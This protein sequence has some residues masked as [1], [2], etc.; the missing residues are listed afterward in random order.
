MENKKVSV[1]IPVYN[2]EATIV[3]AMKSVIEQKYHDWEM[4]LIDDGSTDSSA[5]AIKDYLKSLLPDSERKIFYY[6]QKNAG[7]SKARNFGIGKA[8]GRFIAFLDSDDEWTSD[9]LQLQVSYCENKK[10][11][12]IS[13]GFNKS[14]YESKKGEFTEIALNQ[15]LLRNNFM[16]CSVLIDLEVI[17]KKEVFFN[18]SQKY[19]EDYRLWLMICADYPCIYI[20]KVI[21]MSITNKYNYGASGLSAQLWKMEKGE[22]SNY[23]YLKNQ[24]KISILY[25]Y[26]F[27][28]ISV[29]KYLIRIIKVKIR[30]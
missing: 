22:L 13:G 16:T 21:C 1:I 5:L 4:F 23:K 18:E 9:K 24:K 28:Q 17:D 8:T 30:K 29:I 2:A 6:Y 15:L 27:S 20:N 7:P 12:L 10:N 11:A 26:I 25:Y 14:I 19:A 3:G